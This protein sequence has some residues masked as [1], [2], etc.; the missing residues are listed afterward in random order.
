M[1]MLSW[2]EKTQTLIKEYTFRHLHEESPKLTEKC[3]L[4]AGAVLRDASA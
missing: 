1:I 4:F 2:S 3:D